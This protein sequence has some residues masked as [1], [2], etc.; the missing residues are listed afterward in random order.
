VHQVAAT[1]VVIL[2]CNASLAGGSTTLS[3]IENCPRIGGDGYILHLRN[4]QSETEFAGGFTGIV[5][6]A[7]SRNDYL[8]ASPMKEA[9]N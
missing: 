2:A 9:A 7:I 3:V 6:D 1:A 8:I 5:A 4:Y